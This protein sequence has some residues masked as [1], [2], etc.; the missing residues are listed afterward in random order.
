MLPFLINLVSHPANVSVLCTRL[1]L[2]TKKS[3]I[4]GTET[5]TILP[6][7]WQSSSQTVLIPDWLIFLLWFSNQQMYQQQ[8]VAVGAAPILIQQPGGGQVLVQN[9]SQFPPSPPIF[10]EIFKNSR[11]ALG[12]NA[13]FEGR[14]SGWPRPTVTW[15]R[16]NLP[17][18]S[19]WRFMQKRWMNCD[20]WN[21]F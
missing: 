7:F 1:F 9:I 15:L 13:L 6:E 21:V 14:I 10:V 12:D 11:F 18:P 2:N 17:L 3:C 20:G 5:T 16:K 19:E 8:P 4:G